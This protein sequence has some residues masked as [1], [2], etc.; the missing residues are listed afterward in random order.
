MNELFKL[1]LTFIC[2]RSRQVLT[3]DLNTLDALN[4]PL[5]RF[6]KAKVSLPQEEISRNS[7]VVND[8]LSMIL[9]KIRNED[10]RFSLKQLNTGMRFKKVSSTRRFPIPFTVLKIVCSF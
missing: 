9:E 7:K 2:Y 8:L 1:I 6:F 5:L 10:D 3:W 4:S